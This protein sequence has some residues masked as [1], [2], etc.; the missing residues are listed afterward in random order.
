[1]LKDTVIKNME[2]K[3]YL[4]SDSALL[5]IKKYALHQL[6]LKLPLDENS[7]D[8]IL[9]YAMDLELNA[10]DEDGNDLLENKIGEKEKLA[11]KFGTEM[12]L[13]TDEIIDLVDLNQRL[14]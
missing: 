14:K 12:S 10:I 2:N 8:V 4:L 7:L 9:E 11:D 13:H 5:F 3:K 6:D 1:M